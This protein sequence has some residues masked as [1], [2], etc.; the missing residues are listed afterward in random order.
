MQT[1][2]NNKSYLLLHIYFSVWGFSELHKQCQWGATTEK[3]LMS[4]KNKKN[5][6]TCKKLEKIKNVLILFQHL[7]K[8]C[9]GFIQKL[10]PTGSKA[11]K[12]PDVWSRFFTSDIYKVKH[13]EK[14]L[15]LL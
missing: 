7:Y 15:R 2:I 5:C 1:Y 10:K 9:M 14:N 13:K 3:N 6:I 11:H 12:N 4:A 8:K